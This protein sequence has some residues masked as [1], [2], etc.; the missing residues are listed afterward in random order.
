MAAFP[1]DILQYMMLLPFNVLSLITAGNHQAPARE[2]RGRRH[3][4]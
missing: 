3:M 4:V 2:Y 1:N